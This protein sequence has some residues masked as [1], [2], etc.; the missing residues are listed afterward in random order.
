MSSVTLRTATA[1]DAGTIAALVRELAEYERE[2]EAATATPDD[3]A[4][5]LTAGTGV[6]CLL[7]EVDGPDGPRVAGMALWYTTF[8]T[9]QG[10]AG[11]HLEDLFVRPEHRRS[12][13]GRAFFGE[14][15]RICA[16]RGFGRLEWSVL[17]WNTP[18]QDFYAALGAVPMD[19]WTVWRL[20]GGPLDRL[21]SAPTA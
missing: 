19:G 2:P 12:G 16:E 5:A 8:S 4:R 15:A 14:L 6:G 21:R 18:A 9:W 10:R 3:F 11:M 20:D 1:Q 7:A 17:D 13:I